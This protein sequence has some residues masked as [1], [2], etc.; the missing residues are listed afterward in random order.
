MYQKVYTLLIPM[1]DTTHSILNGR[2]F[3]LKI[4]PVS[5]HLTMF[6]P[7]HQ[8][9]LMESTSVVNRHDSANGVVEVT[10]ASGTTYFLK[11]LNFLLPTIPSE[12]SDPKPVSQEE[13]D[14]KA[15]KEFYERILNEN[16]RLRE[17]LA[18]Y[19]KKANDNVISEEVEALKGSIIDIF[20]DYRE[21]NYRD[22][23]RSKTYT[24][25][26]NVTEEQFKALCIAEGL[27]LKP[28]GEW[29]ENYNEIFCVDGNPCQWCWKEILRYTD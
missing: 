12:P 24:F 7:I 2:I 9:I 8:E 28:K 14:D 22:G 21:I 5:K 29:Y 3:K 11:R 17:E 6:D 26:S 27:D 25:M 19:K 13:Y 4:D 20:D 18:E 15:V 16:Q 23:Y 1:E 10:T